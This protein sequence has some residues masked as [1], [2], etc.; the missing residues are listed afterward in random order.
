MTTTPDI[1]TE[2]LEAAKEAARRAAHA[3]QYVWPD[4]AER[5]AERAVAAAAPHLIAEGRRQRDQELFAASVEPDGPV[6]DETPALVAR[7]ER[8]VRAKVA[9]EIRGA[10]AREEQPKIWTRRGTY[11]LD[12]G[13]PEWAA[14][15]AEGGTGG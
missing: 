11:I 13:I 5:V 2:A 1:P 7:F 8:E 9:A 6:Q 3:D 14:R 10:A 12:G 15:I 4:T